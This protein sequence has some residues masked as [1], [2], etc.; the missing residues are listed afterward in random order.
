MYNINVEAISSDPAAFLMIG[1][2]GGGRDK[3]RKRQT[4]AVVN[5]ACIRGDQGI[6]GAPEYVNRNFTLANVQNLNLDDLSKF[7]MASSA[8]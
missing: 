3:R 1:A 6:P 7:Q 5:M 2:G 8:S 4:T